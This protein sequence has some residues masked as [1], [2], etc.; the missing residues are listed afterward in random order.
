MKYV[1]VD[2]KQEME[3]RLKDS[4]RL[5]FLLSLLKSGKYEL[6]TGADGGG[7]RTLCYQETLD[8]IKK[9]DIK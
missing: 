7:H 3:E 5:I 4:D 2:F 8:L 6:I 9:E 1:S